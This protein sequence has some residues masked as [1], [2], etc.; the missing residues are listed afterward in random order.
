VLII[1]LV[2]SLIIGLSA[3]IIVNKRKTRKIQ[4]DQHS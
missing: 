1:A 4:L 2:T 3:A